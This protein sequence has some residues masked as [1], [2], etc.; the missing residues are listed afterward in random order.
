MQKLL[1]VRELFAE[2]LIED[3]DQLEAE[4][5]LDAGQHHAAL[6]EQVCGGGIE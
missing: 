3:R 1:P 2:A 5:R 6:L 4:E